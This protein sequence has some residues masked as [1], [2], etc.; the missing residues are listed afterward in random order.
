MSLLFAV[1]YSTFKVLIGIFLLR[2][3]PSSRRRQFL[4]YFFN[5]RIPTLFHLVIFRAAG[6]QGLKI[7]RVFKQFFTGRATLPTTGQHYAF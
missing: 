7:G 2:M 6:R 1:S 3:Q 5:S 4:I